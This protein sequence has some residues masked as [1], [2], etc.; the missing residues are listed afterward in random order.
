MNSQSP[1]VSVVTITYGHQEYI[2]ETIKGVLMQ[3]YNGDIEFII[4]NDNSPDDTHSI[5][6]NFLNTNP[7]PIGFQV[8]YTKHENNLG[9]MP[10]FIWAL[11]Q[12]TGNYIAIC[13]GDDYWI[14]PLKLKKQVDFL[15]VN[16]EYGLVGTSI[17]R[18]NDSIGKLSEIKFK[19][20]VYIFDDFIESNRIATL[21]SC[22]KSEL[23]YDYLKVIDPYSKN[24]YS[25]DYPM[26][27]YFSSKKKVKILSD[28]TA[29]YRVLEESASNTKDINKKLYINKYRHDVRKFYLDFNNCKTDKRRKVDLISY[30]EAQENA[31]LL[32]DNEYCNEIL[33]FYES[34]GYN[35]LSLLM[36]ISIKYPFF[37]PL[38]YFIERVLIKFR[39]IRFF[40]IINL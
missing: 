14:D 1:K 18:L 19:E 27:L 30:R 8:K 34:N 10:N 2:L 4:A 6:T 7:I 32:G 35:G 15:E 3:E 22:F 28:V 13:E 29:V 20:A 16:E 9:M 39:I 17:C 21:T 33:N 25:G 12:A 24:W 37:R 23:Y 11:Q 36:K 5:V 31:V 26:W 40:K 38:I